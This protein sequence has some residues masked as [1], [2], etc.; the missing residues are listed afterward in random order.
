MVG[1]ERIAWMAG[2]RVKMITRAIDTMGADA[3][4]AIPIGSVV[5]VS[6]HESSIVSHDEAIGMLFDQ[7][8]EWAKVG[9]PN[10]GEAAALASRLGAI[11][12]ASY[13]TL[14]AFHEGA[15]AHI[16]PRGPSRS[17]DETGR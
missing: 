12:A 9:I 17:A 14:I 10:V 8:D 3:L 15:T 7:I 5:V 6:E 11:D 1:A 16:W 2:M 13:V 4:R